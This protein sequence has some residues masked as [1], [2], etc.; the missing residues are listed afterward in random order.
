M[1]SIQ[2]DMFPRRTSVSRSLSATICWLR[3]SLL[4]SCLGLLSACAVAVPTSAPAGSSAIPDSAKVAPALQMALQG[5]DQGKS[6]N[7]KRVAEDT[8]GRIQVYVYVRRAPGEV[9]ARLQQAGLTH[10]VNVP[11]LNVVEGWVIP[12]RIPALTKLSW[13]TRISLPR[14]ARPR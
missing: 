14:Y 8:Q 6:A 3:G 7:L 5:L 12:S 10:M 2:H 11:E 1:W 13:V 9:L 4:A